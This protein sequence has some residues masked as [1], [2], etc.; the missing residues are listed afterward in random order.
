MNALCGRDGGDKFLPF[1]LFDP[2]G[3]TL[4]MNTVLEY[5]RYVRQ[6]LDKK[7]ETVEE[8]AKGTFQTDLILKGPGGLPL[9]P[10]PSVGVKGHEVAEILKDVVREYFTT[11]YSK[12]NVFDVLLAEAKANMN[13]D[14]PQGELLPAPPGRPS[15]KIPVNFL[16][17]GAFPMDSGSRIRAEWVSQ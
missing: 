14:L 6:K 9:L 8:P 5:T 10:K 16:T 13:Q 2:K 7:G 15:V 17:R 12:S 1:H 3:Y 11:H 4:V